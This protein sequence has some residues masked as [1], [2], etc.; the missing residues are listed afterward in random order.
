[1]EAV[2]EAASTH[3]VSSSIEMEDQNDNLS[4]MLSANVSGRGTPNVSG[5]NTPLSIA[6]QEE[7]NA[8]NDD[9]DMVME[10]IRDGVAENPPLPQEHNPPHLPNLNLNNRPRPDPSKQARSEIE[11]K[12]CKFEIKKMLGGDETY[13]LVSDTW[14]TD[15]LASDSEMGGEAQQALNQLGQLNMGSRNSSVSAPPIIELPSALQDSNSNNDTMSEVILML[16]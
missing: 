3:S 15:V 10:E 14:S 16:H 11:D 13:S 7:G 9:N 5:R 8:N 12:F 4:D 6:E 1:M 2:S